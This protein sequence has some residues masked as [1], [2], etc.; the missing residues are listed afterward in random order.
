M[1]F[2]PLALGSLLQEAAGRHGGS[3]AGL[4]AG[5]GGA[6]A[7]LSGSGARGAAALEDSGPAAAGAAGGDALGERPPPRLPSKFFFFYIFKVIIST[8]R[9][10][11]V[12]SLMK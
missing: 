1:H 5:R 10:S 11:V 8:V 4:R 2:I 9:G 7:A 12:Y 3:A 6:A